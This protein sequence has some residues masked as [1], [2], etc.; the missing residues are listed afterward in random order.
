MPSRN[1]GVIDL[2]VDLPNAPLV[3]LLNSWLVVWD[4]VKLDSAYCNKRTRPILLQALALSTITDIDVWISYD[5]Q[6]TW[7]IARKVKCSDLLF[8]VGWIPEKDIL[9]SFLSCVGPA[10]TTIFFLKSEVEEEFMYDRGVF[11]L[12]AQYCPKLRNLSCRKHGFYFSSLVEVIAQCHYLRDL[13]LCG[14]QHIPGNFLVSCFAAPCLE[15][16]D[17]SKCTFL[18]DCG[19]VEL[20]QSQAMRSLYVTETNLSEETVLRMCA[21]SPQ[22]TTLSAGPMICKQGPLPLVK[23]AQS[24]PCMQNCSISGSDGTLIDA[25]AATTIAT[26]WTRI[27]QLTLELKQGLFNDKN[28]SACTEEALLVLIQRCPQLRILSVKESAVHIT[29]TPSESPTIASTNKSKMTDLQISSI[30]A[31][32]LR[33]ILSVCTSLRRLHIVSDVPTQE[34]RVNGTI[35]AE[36]SLHLLHN[37]SVQ[38]LMLEGTKHL[39]DTK[40]GHIA[41]LKELYLRDISGDFTAEHVFQLLQRCP[42][43][44]TLVLVELAVNDNLNIRHIIEACPKVCRFAFSTAGGSKHNT[45][46]MATLREVLQHFYPRLEQLALNF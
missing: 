7:M 23:I 24:C 15:A 30:S 42:D 34:Q 11:T 3:D 35:M 6:R 14:S 21:S 9:V 33:T 39:N 28:V 22:L 19:N 40:L 5:E 46:S 38:A 20:V 32:S 37:T 36:D 45:A 12:I 31:A 27:E 43:L 18:R 25:A 41:G 4:V 2:V 13:N 10:V 29:K 17:L 44:D 8:R 1:C 16:L 26:V